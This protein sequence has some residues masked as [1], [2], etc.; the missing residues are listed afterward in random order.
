MCRSGGCI[1][2]PR[3]TY[4]TKGTPGSAFGEGVTNCTPCNG[5][6]EDTCVDYAG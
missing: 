5:C 6:L 2:C 3:G 1:A 4:L